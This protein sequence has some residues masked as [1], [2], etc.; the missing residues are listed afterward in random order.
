MLTIHIYTPG[1]FE[2]CNNLVDP[3]PY[4]NMCQ[5]DVCH[6][7]HKF[8]ADATSCKCSV[9][10]AYARECAIAGRP[11]VWRDETSCSVPCLDGRVWKECIDDCDVTCEM[12]S[13]G[14]QCNT[15]LECVEGCECA[16]GEVFDSSIGRCVSKSSCSCYHR[17]VVYPHGSARRSV[18]SSCECRGGEWACDAITGCSR[19][20]LCENGQ[21][22]SNC[23]E[24]QQTCDNMHVKCE[25]V[26]C[27]EGCTCANGTVLSGGK[28]IR[29]EQCSCHFRGR[30]YRDGQWVKRDCNFCRCRNTMW[31]CTERDCPAYCSAY[32][33]P[34]YESF[35]KRRFEFHGDCTYV[36]SEDFCGDGVGS[37]RVTVENVPCS[38]GGVTCTKAVKL[39]LY[40][41][42]IQ[43]IRGVEPI[44]SKN[45][46][47]RAGTPKADFKITRAGL[48]LIVKTKIGLTILWDV[49]TRVYVKLEPKFKRKVCGLCGDFDGNALNDLKT[50]QGELE[51]SVHM[52][53]DT[54]K[55]YSSCPRSEDDPVHPCIVSPQRADW[56]RLSCR[57]IRESPFSSCHAFVDPEPYYASCVWDSCGCD[58]GGD[59]ECLCTAVAAYVRECNEMGV[60]IRWR[61][62]GSCGLQ[63]EA[64]KV[65]EECGTTCSSSCWSGTSDEGCTNT[66]VEGCHCPNGTVMHDGKCIERMQCPCKVGNLVIP[67]GVSLKYNCMDCMC[68][69]S[70]LRCSG[71]PCGQT[72]EATT[73]S[74]NVTSQ[75]TTMTS[76]YT[77]QP[78]TTP[79]NETTTDIVCDEG[80]EEVDCIG[81]PQRCHYINNE[82]CDETMA[83]V[84]GCSCPVGKVVGEDGACVEPTTCACVD[85]AGVVHEPDSTWKRGLCERCS[86]FNNNISCHNIQCDQ[87]PCNESDGMSLVHIAGVCCPVCVPATTFPIM[88][89]T[90]QPNVTMT[91]QPVCDENEVYGIC[92]CTP[93]C[94]DVNNNRSCVMSSMGEQCCSCKEGMAIDDVTNR[95]IPVEQC[96]C[97]TNNGVTV[98]VGETY[99]RGCERCACI[100]GVLR[101]ATY[102]PVESCDGGMILQRD[103]NGCCYCDEKSTTPPH[104]VTTEPTCACEPGYSPCNDCSHCYRDDARCDDVITCD[105]G[106]DE[107]G[108]PCIH[109]NKKHNEQWWVSDCESCTCNNGMTSCNKTCSLKCEDG[110]QLNLPSDENCCTCEPVAGTTTIMTSSSPIMISSAPVMTSSSPIMTS[111][112]PVMISSA[113]VM[114]SS[115]PIMTSSAPVMTSSASIVTTT[116]MS[117]TSVTP[118]CDEAMGMESGIIDD[119]LVDASSYL[120]GR[121]PHYARVN[122]GGSWSPKE[123]DTDPYLEVS[124]LEVAELTAIS[125][126]GGNDGLYVSEYMVEYATKNDIIMVADSLGNPIV[127]QGNNDDSTIHKNEFPRPINV[128]RIRIFPLSR[129]NGISLRIELHGCGRTIETTTNVVTTTTEP[130]STVTGG[131]STVTGGVSTVIGGVSIVTGGVS[132]VTGGVSTVN[133]GVS[134]V[135]EPVSTVTGGMS[136]VTGG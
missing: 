128:K 64:G 28:C 120:P 126:Q 117:K 56:A 72:T 115:A 33:D 111:S 55:V 67:K 8:K 103:D 71:T 114:T 52:F 73:M 131:V 37:F 106:S 102:C 88:T 19:E 74:Y 84:R 16:G 112:A 21:V 29:P 24:C 124:F 118:Y 43:M 57:A 98:L 32:G 68:V 47:A 1:A 20:S 109:D 5:H 17:N 121:E 94:A 59:C 38:T 90:I 39:T 61:A 40:D 54:W 3:S 75:Y 127:F 135:T 13:T 87:A 133:E 107:S 41:T 22:W 122:S 18:C 30:S 79:P 63:C 23:T 136:T 45:P 69:D 96:P 123:T 132:T 77:T 36:L 48:F 97:V 11:L 104:E 2:A 80:M 108:C 119:Q 34:H 125:T 91:S 129:N 82:D 110:F 134:T 7:M 81:C 93:T 42:I 92:T 51:S 105:D 58:R 95:C 46:F 60:H 86:C 66:C 25:Q 130:V 83:C 50:R 89:S 101:C 100:A 4:I 6:C 62:T 70:N 44:V 113:P 26:K 31:E 35:D 12:I 85:D 78:V 116:V 14:N 27:T 53:G 76:Q 10:S 15:S 9:F 65:Y 99:E 49:G